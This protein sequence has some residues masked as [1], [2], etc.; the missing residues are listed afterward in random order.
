MMTVGKAVTKATSETSTTATT[1]TMQ[2]R[3]G[4]LTAV[5]LQVTSQRISMSSF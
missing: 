4:G 1:S 3:A 2:G 5:T